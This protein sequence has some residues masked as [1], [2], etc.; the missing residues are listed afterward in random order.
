M[1]EFIYYNASGLDFP[2]SEKI[3]VTT[4]IEDT[5][6][7]N[8]LISNSKDIN[9][10]LSALEIDFYIKNSQDDLSKKIKNVLELYEIA[11]IKY[12]FSQDIAQTIEISNSLLIISSTNEEYEGF[13]SNLQNG[14]FEL[15]KVDELVLKS[16]EGTIG[17]FAVTVMSNDKEVV[18][19]VSQIVWFNEKQNKKRTGIY[20]GSL[21]E[22][23]DLIQ[24]L[25]NN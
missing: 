22:T 13:V 3:F 2:V 10:E 6:N 17:N 11:A 4:N 1:Q 7:K 5:K 14:D 20:D 15:F 18:L 24:T 16:I 9:S 25:K 19:N 8:F 12:D 23:D 21:I